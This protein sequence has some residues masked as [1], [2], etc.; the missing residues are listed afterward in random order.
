MTRHKTNEQPKETDMY[1]DYESPNILKSF[2][3]G[4]GPQRYAPPNYMTLSFQFKGGTFS[5]SHP[6]ALAIFFLI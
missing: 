3:G 5:V 4:T 6:N 1:M 2:A